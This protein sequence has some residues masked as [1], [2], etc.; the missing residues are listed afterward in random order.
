MKNKHFSIH[1]L[2]SG[3]VIS[4]SL[5]LFACEEV[6]QDIDFPQSDPVLVIHAHISPDDSMI[7]VV[8]ST[9]KP[10][11]NKPPKPDMQYISNATVTVECGGNSMILP[12]D[13]T[14]RDY[15][16][17]SA[18]LQ[19]SP[20]K[21][22]TVTATAPGFDIAT[23]STTI[24][25]VRNTQL[26]I[27]STSI[28]SSDNGWDSYGKRVIFKLRAK[29]IPN[30]ENFYRFYA[31]QEEYDSTYGYR[32][33]PLYPTLGNEITSDKGKDGEYL[34]ITYESYYSTD[35]CNFSLNLLTT[36]NVYY[37]Y[38]NS[39]QNMQSEFFFA[40]PTI[41]ISNIKGGLGV[42]TSYLRHKKEITLILP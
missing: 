24:P 6:V 7:R 10:L 42:I 27:I 28:D 30:T 13:Y 35:T 8:V 32:F 36:D 29:D 39:I 38:H 23:G 12:Y 31:F 11:F 41:I 16:A 18:P 21:T 17:L 14:D 4:A 40:E 22:V 15:K 33:N 26:E 34:Y 25:S 19:L 5:F 20:G 2:I 37:R 1:R 3:I 9:N